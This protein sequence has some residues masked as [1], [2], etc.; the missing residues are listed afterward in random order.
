MPARLIE[1]PAEEPVTLAEAKA[2][3]RLDSA[4]D[5]AHVEMLITAARQYVEELCWRG[6]VTQQLELV[7]DG[8]HGE[9]A[10]ELPGWVRSQFRMGEPIELPRGN[11]ADLSNNDPAVESVKYIDAGGVERT[12]ATSEYSVDDVSVPGRVMPAPGKVWPPTQSGR[13][14]A[15]RI[16]YSVGWAVADVPVALKQAMLLALSQM[17]EKRTPEIG[18]MPAVLAL[19]GPY[20]LNK[21]G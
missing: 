14:D 4:L 13:W 20:R 2:Q 18:E 1:A 16:V 15:V 3:L 6:I 10:L 5:D 11:L 8:F 9:S 21:V 19:C 7:L 12:L 17:Y